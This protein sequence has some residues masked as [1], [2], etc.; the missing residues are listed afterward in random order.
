[1]EGAC[2][3]GLSRGPPF[4]AELD[5]SWL[6][7]ANWLVLPWYCIIMVTCQ[8]CVSPQG[9]APATLQYRSPGSSA[10][11]QQE[12]LQR[13]GLERAGYIMQGHA[14]DLKARRGAKNGM[15]QTQLGPQVGAV[16]C[17]WWQMEG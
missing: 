2:Q 3:A 13:A 8:P 4:G 1:M 5:Q 10:S 12:I 14:A 6:T 11:R 17:G 7:H 9:L 16:G 15:Q